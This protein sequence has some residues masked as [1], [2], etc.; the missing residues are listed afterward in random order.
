VFVVSGPGGAGKNTIVDRVL[1]A[2]PTLRE[3]RS[4]TT[5]ERRPGE[6]EDAYTFVDRAT[7]EAAIE[8]DRFLEWA[9]YV[10][11]LYGT[12][13]PGPVPDTDLVLVIEVQGARQVL[14]RVPDAVMILVVPPS[15][16]VQEARLRARG[17]S[18]EHVQ[19]RLAVADEEEQVGRAL[20]HHVVV[21]DDLDRAVQEVAGILDGYRRP[22][23]S[24]SST[25]E[26][27]V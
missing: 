25:S 20:A 4:W 1:A 15:R 24:A 16:R 14:E 19:K 17:D 5:R 3:S 7:F 23:P 26:G 11:N 10:G 18:E 22:P 12:P 13:W 27:T 9:E 21:N 8:A 2:D 6:G